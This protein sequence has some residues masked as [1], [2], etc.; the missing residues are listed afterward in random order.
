MSYSQRIF[1]RRQNLS[2]RWEINGRCLV[3]IIGIPFTEKYKIAGQ[4]AINPADA[5]QEVFQ[6]HLYVYLFIT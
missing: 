4:K 3:D 6:M 1:T 5:D 2:N